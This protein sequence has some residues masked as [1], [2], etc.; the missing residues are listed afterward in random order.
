MGKYSCGT[1][2]FGSNGEKMIIVDLDGETPIGIRLRSRAR[3]N[4]TE[5]GEIDGEGTFDGTNSTAEAIWPGGSK[6]WPYT[7]EPSYCGVTY[8][9]AGAK[10]VSAKPSTVNPPFEPDQVN[11]NVDAHDSSYPMVL[12]AW[13]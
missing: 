6:A 10:K 9:A 1:V 2:S 8:S 7:A 11:L 12:E 4:T 3:A 5:A 13:S